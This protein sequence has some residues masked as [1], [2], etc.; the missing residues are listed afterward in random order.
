MSKV[1]IIGGGI[2]GIASA[3]ALQADGREVNVI[4]RG[5]PTEAASFGNCGLLAVGEVVPISKPGVLRKI[6]GW[7]ADPKGPLHVRPSALVP[8]LPWLLRFLWSGRAA[9]VKEIAAGM[10]PLLHRAED[11]WRAAFADA[12][13]PEALIASENLI[14]MN[15]RSDYEADTFTWG[16]RQL[17]GFGHRFVGTDELRQMEPALGG[18]IT[19]GVLAKGWLQFADPGAI[20]QGLHAVFRQRGG[21]IITGNAVRIET[22]GQRATGVHLD[23]GERVAAETLVVAAGAWSGKLARD[24]GLRIPVAALQGY[25]HQLPRPGA[26]LNRPILYANGGFV[27]TPLTSGLRI[28]GTIEVAGHDPKPN[29][30]RADILA[31]KARTIVPGLDTSGATQ[32]MGPRPFMPDT[33]P[34]IGR[35]PGQENVILA[36]GHGQVGQTLGATTGRIVA[37]LVATRRPP[38]DL[39]PYRPTRF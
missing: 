1:T 39:S 12:G 9:R 38:I 7:L 30:A 32:W 31:D 10:A 5:H 23:S 35:A 3:L 13:M 33:M 28:G 37:D 22:S 17:H 26:V 36:F 21:K 34:V 25:H 29:F 20:L 27:L 11:D 15:A 16:L 8:Q 14:A 19:C 18:P 6:P 4:D 2:V 24:L